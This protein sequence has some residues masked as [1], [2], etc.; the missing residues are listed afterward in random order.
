MDPGT[1]K[2]DD[3][4]EEKLLAGVSFEDLPIGTLLRKTA[5][6]TWEIV[7]EE[8]SKISHEILRPSGETPSSHAET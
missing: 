3:G 5:M 7:N 4:S 2:P 8:P 1:K 6:H